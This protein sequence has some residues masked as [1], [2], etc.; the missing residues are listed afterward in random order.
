M[1]INELKMTE[2]KTLS[3]TELE[4]LVNDLKKKHTNKG[5]TDVETKILKGIFDDKT[6]R[7]LAKEIRQEEQSIKNAASSL[8]KILSEQTGEKIEKSNLITALA[9]YRDNSQTFDHNN[10]PQTQQS[11][12][13]F[14]LVIEVG[15]D[16]LTPEKIDKINNLIQKIARDNTIKPIMKLK[17]SIRLFL[18]GSEDG[19]QRLAD[20][21]QSG[22]LQALLNKLKSDDIPEI[23]VKKAKFTTDAKV[24]EKAELIKAIR[25]GTIDETTLRFVD[26][27]G[28]ILIEADLSGANLS[29]ADLSGANL[30]EAI[31]SEAD[32]S[33]AILWTAKLSWAHL[34]GADLS[35][36]NLSEADLSEADLSEADLSE[37]I[38][39]GANLSE[40]DLSWANL[41]GANLIQANLRGANLSNA[42][43]WTAKLSWAYLWGA[44]LSGANLSEAD[45]SGANL[46]EADLSGANLRG[47]NLSGADLWGA[48]LIEAD[49]R[50]AFLSEA[51]LSEAIL[52]GAKVENAIFIDATGITPEQK[53]DLIRRGAIFGDNSNDRSKVLV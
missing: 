9:R 15:I 27:S 3:W 18:E 47:A 52:S 26:L 45:L 31:L 49:L 53:Q 12:K 51:N 17:G 34:W 5:L 6:Y 30:S 35:G 2:I 28:A 21:H 39:R 43:L 48:N 8:F 41:R 25:E 20:L 24:I 23:I 7:D 33:E 50:G 42:I 19:L 44:N 38:L 13:V 1:M 32:L 37:A 36:A 14:E 29:E 46:S 40:A 22:E 16:D 4:M 10:Q 11:D